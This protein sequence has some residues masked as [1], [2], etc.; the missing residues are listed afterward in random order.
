MMTFIVIAA[1]MGLAVAALLAVPLLS[2]RPVAPPSPL[3]A[4]VVLVVLLGGAAGLY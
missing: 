3:T 1:A 2:R 4:L